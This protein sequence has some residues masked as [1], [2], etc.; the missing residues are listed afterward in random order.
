M[1]AIETINYN[2]HKINVYYD[3]FAESPRAWDNLS[4]IYSNSRRYNP[5]NLDIYDLMR[6]I[7]ISEFPGFDAILE[8]ME[9]DYIAY[10]VCVVDHSYVALS[11]SSPVPNPYM[12]FDSGTLGI[13][14]VSK[15]AVRREYKVKRI[16]KKIREKVESIF[17]G[18]LNTLEKYINGEVYGYM[19]D[20]GDMD[21][22]WGFYSMEHA[23]EEAKSIID[24]SSVVAA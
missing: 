17:E 7:G 16:T 13:I 3:E 4:M 24:S 5:D 22:C 8:R 11:L 12:G 21:S 23:I 2:G 19:I 1:N 6:E 9:H 10:R 18:E 15:D 14:A 20:D